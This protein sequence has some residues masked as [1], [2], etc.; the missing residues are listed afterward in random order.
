M[1]V[2]ELCDQRAMVDALRIVEVADV[3]PPILTVSLPLPCLERGQCK[4]AGVAPESLVGPHALGRDAPASRQDVQA[5]VGLRA[6][7][8]PLGTYGNGELN[9][10]EE[11]R[12][13]GRRKET[14]S[15]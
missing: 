8:L 6:S 10:K 1:F 12:V 2:Y 7:A 14:A 9:K 15:E 11:R 13:W 4:E 5:S 3:R